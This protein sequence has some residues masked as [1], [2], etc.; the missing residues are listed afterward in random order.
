MRSTNFSTSFVWISIPIPNIFGQEMFTSRRLHRPPVPRNAG[1]R[2]GTPWIGSCREVVATVA[3]V[4]CGYRPL[5][6]GKYHRM[7]MA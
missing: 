6:L 5:K 2:G 4:M 3:T 7:Y 1:R